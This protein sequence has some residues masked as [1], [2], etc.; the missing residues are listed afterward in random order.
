MLWINTRDLINNDIKLTFGHKDTKWKKNV[1]E[2]LKPNHN[3]PGWFNGSHIEIERKKA[4]F[5]SFT[6]IL[7]NF[8][9]KMERSQHICTDRK[10]TYF[11]DFTHFNA[12]ETFGNRQYIILCMVD[13][14]EGKHICKLLVRC[15]NENF[16]CAYATQM[17]VMPMKNLLHMISVRQW[18][19]WVWILNTCYLKFHNAARTYIYIYTDQVYI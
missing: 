13:V 19:N 4:F 1:M 14:V 9:L 15:R 8:R 5:S 17:H 12:M 2:I 18:F 16:I 10:K 6:S 7:L 11:A 3:R